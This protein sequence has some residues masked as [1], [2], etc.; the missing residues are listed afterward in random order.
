LFSSSL[1]HQKR[2]CL[3]FNFASGDNIFGGSATDAAESL[4]RAISPAM[5]YKVPW[6]AILGNH[7]QESTM[8]R[9]ELMTFMSL[10]D[11][12]V[13]QVNPPG[14]LVH[15]F[16]NYHVGIHGPFGSGLVNTS[17]LN[18]YFL[19]S[20]DREVVDGIK[21][22]GWIR[23]SQLA[24][25]S[26]TSKEL[27]VLVINIDLTTAPK[28]SVCN[29]LVIGSLRMK[30]ISTSI[31]MTYLLV[32]NPCLFC[33]R[34]MN[35]FVVSLLVYSVHILPVFEPMSDPHYRMCSMLISYS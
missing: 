31:K 26:A 14:F 28:I 17:L 25:L 22:Y 30:M 13:S 24:W 32:Y 15:G 12:S 33:Y 20:G 1:N 7:D 9:E 10:M 27:Q 23:E 8:T 3:C 4:L 11:Y 18:L 5:E 19:D 34:L 35:S 29:V 16:G 6:A 2:Q 21:T